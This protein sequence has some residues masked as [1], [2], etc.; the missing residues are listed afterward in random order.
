MTARLPSARVLWLKSQLSVTEHGHVVYERFRKDTLPKKEH[1]DHSWTPIFREMMGEIETLKDGVFTTHD[2]S[3]YLEIGKKL[4]LMAEA[5]FEREKGILIG[6][7]G[8]TIRGLKLDA[9]LPF[10]KALNLAFAFSDDDSYKR[11]ISHLASRARRDQLATMLPEGLSKKERDMALEKISA[12]IPPTFAAYFTSNL[13]REIEKTVMIAVQSKEF[14]VDQLADEIEKMLFDEV[15]KQ[16]VHTAKDKGKIGER[17][18]SKETAVIGDIRDY[19][20]AVVWLINN[21]TEL[22]SNFT[23]IINPDL[24]R[25]ANEEER[26]EIATAVAYVGEHGLTPRAREKVK[27][28]FRKIIPHS[29]EQARRGGHFNEAFGT[30]IYNSLAE[31]RGDASRATQVLNEIASID[32][33]IVGDIFDELVRDSTDQILAAMSGKG[34][35]SKEG[36]RKKLANYL[37]T[38]PSIK[39]GPFIGFVNAKQSGMGG[40]FKKL[41][42]FSAGKNLNANEMES[43]I[44][45]VDSR[46]KSANLGENWIKASRLLY[47]AMEN[48]VH[49]G[50]TSFM[51]PARRLLSTAIAFMLFDDWEEIGATDQ[52][53][54]IH[55]MSLN[56]FYVPLSYLL[57]HMAKC[58]IENDFD[59]LKN[60]VSSHIHI[61]TAGVDREG[62]PEKGEKTGKLFAGSDVL[63]NWNRQAAD[64]R[65]KLE[66]SLN[67]MGGIN[68]LMLN[69]SAA[70][71]LDFRQDS[72][73]G[74]MKRVEEAKQAIEKI[75]TT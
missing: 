62:D 28:A 14:D 20:D 1:R 67:F 25:K 58:Y 5:E 48:A 23:R 51:V 70:E 34:A 42:G 63:T 61:R 9:S 11:R 17:E 65:E 60:Y 12:G 64:I 35:S 7:Y 54:V 41:G 74:E 36:I 38:L 53:N 43:I 46:S 27:E 45:Q 56:E 13:V 73:Y 68:D 59:T 22:D 72:S 33:V 29:G 47:Q 71:E 31:K 32:M 21:L 55:L 44:N 8:L 50:K 40:T 19:Q 4:H 18:W 24:L 49:Q 26:E 66:F 39:E 75:M 2:K 37:N 16:L 52:H 30:A 69:L 3:L 15:K 10:I 6:H 57:Y